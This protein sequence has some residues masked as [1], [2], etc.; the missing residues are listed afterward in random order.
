LTIARNSFYRLGCTMPP[1]VEQL[2]AFL[3]QHTTPEARILVEDSEAFNKP[4]YFEAEAY[5]GTHVPGLFP[6]LLKREYL[7]GPR[8]MYPIKHSFASFTRGVLFDRPI[9]DYT[10][11]E[12]Q[13][14]FDL[15]NVRWIVC[16]FDDSRAAFDAWPQYIRKVGAVDK[17]TVYE[18][19]REPSFF[20]KGSGRVTSDYNRLELTDV[21]PEDGEAII[22]YHWMKY[23]V[24]DSGAE[25]ERVMLGGDPIGFI[26]IKNPPARL[27][28]YN[29]Y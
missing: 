29:D 5:Y 14:A 24:T 1:A 12:L 16:W 10:F 21:Q 4:G 11:S 13:A 27:T 2:V 19:L 22:S 9:A 23:L 25:L 8:P 18:V 7:C 17:F 15:F 6:F 3:A 26:K 20:I 28:I